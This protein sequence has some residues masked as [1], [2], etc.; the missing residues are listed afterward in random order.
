MSSLRDLLEG[1]AHDDGVT[2]VEAP[3][4]WSQ[5]R[6]LYGGLT[7]AFC[8][9]AATLAVTDL[10]PL[11]SAQIAFIGP[12]SGR[13]ELRTA[14][15]RRGRAST[16]VGVDCAGE[17]GLA[18]R[19]LFAYGDERSSEVAHD[20]VEAPAVPRPETCDPF[21]PDGAGPAGFFQN[22][23]MRLAGGARPFTGAAPAEMLVWVRYR[24]GSDVD[25][26]AALLAL[27]DSLPPAAMIN[28]SRPA[29]ISTM[30]WSIDLFHPI[31]VGD[32]RLV[33]SASEQARA[34]YSLQSMSVW[35]T[36]G[37]RLAAGRQT[38]AIFI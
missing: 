12:A 14:T 36:A 1:V 28:F 25:P 37:K 6:T 9:R 24:E 34:G 35:D 4:A 26:V 29:A 30:T 17:T 31:I 8:A 20:R 22:F 11:R 5:G 15:L 19:A 21:F 23:E 32:W 18:A 16:F 33:V 2:T 7:A 38:V 3:A 10:P 27:A 13:L